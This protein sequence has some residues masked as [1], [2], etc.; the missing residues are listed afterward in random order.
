[1]KIILNQIFITEDDDNYIRWSTLTKGR[2][3]IPLKR[4]KGMLYFKTVRKRNRTLVINFH[5]NP[6]KEVKERTNNHG[7]NAPVLYEIADFL[8]H[9]TINS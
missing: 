6:F 4:L 7:W 2:H 5:S 9:S 1:M 8:N 3:A